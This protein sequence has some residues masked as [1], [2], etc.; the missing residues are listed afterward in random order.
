MQT[1][2][3]QPRLALVRPLKGNCRMNISA[4]QHSTRFV[5]IDPAREEAQPPQA[6]TTDPEAATAPTVSNETSGG[7]VGGLFHSV[8]TLFQIAGQLNEIAKTA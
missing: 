7:G 5:A 6:A 1:T 4:L 2:E 3:F 8:G